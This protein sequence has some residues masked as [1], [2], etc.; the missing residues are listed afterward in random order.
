[1]LNRN[2]RSDGGHEMKRNI[3]KKIEEV[4]PENSADWKKINN[5][6]HKCMGRSDYVSLENISF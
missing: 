5:T 2:Q 3:R 1:M 6:V 4:F